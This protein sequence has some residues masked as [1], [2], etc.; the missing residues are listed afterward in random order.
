[1]AENSYPVGQEL[2]EI[3]YMSSE[4]EDDEIHPES[5]SAAFSTPLPASPAPGSSQGPSVSPT[6]LNISNL[7]FKRKYTFTAM[8]DSGSVPVR[9]GCTSAD[10]ERVAQ[11][12]GLTEK[13]ARIKQREV[14]R[15]STKRTANMVIMPNSVKY[16]GRFRKN[17]PPI[18]QPKTLTKSGSKNPFRSALLC[19]LHRQM[20]RDFTKE[21]TRR[22]AFSKSV[23]AL[24][25]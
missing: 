20:S 8:G 6:P 10:V 2:A 9:R 15:E 7:A 3:L 14:Q 12:A 22:S 18:T 19:K 4:S 16:N 1:M 17:L 5:I 23:S 24:E 25:K 21:A 13:I 11:E